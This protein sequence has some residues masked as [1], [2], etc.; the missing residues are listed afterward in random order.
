MDQTILILYNHIFKSSILEKNPFLV[1]K[2]HTLG[3]GNMRKG[4][5][6]IILNSADGRLEG[7]YKVGQG[8]NPPIAMVLHPHSGYGGTMDNPVVYSIFT[9]FANLGFSVL[10]INFRGV[11]K[12]TGKFDNGQG[13]LADAATALDWLQAKNPNTN[14]CWVAGFSFGSYIS[15]QLLMRRPEIKR[16]VAVAPQPNIYDFTFLAPCPSSG[17]LVCPDDDPTVPRDSVNKLYEKLKSQ[18]RIEVEMEKCK[19]ANHF[20]TNK[21]TEL[22]NIVKSYI[23]TQVESNDTSL[24]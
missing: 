7:K 3:R 14:E 12:S 24:R 13:E 22:A 5:P 18:K 8:N 9:A 19:G 4:I 20:F 6:S 23:K 1:E 11:G 17:L 2:N 21:E 15:M 16:F 10:R